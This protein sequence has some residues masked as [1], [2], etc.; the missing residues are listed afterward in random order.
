[1][2]TLRIFCRTIVGLVFIFSGFVKG[3][4]PLGSVYKF[5][6]YFE[7]YHT[8]WLSSLSLFLAVFLCAVEFTIGV[9]LV[10]GVKPKLSAWLAFIM[11]FFF[12]G[13]TLLS[14]INNPVSDC[15]CFGDAIKLTNWETFYKNIV[16][17]ILTLVLLLTNK[18]AKPAFS[19]K[20]EITIIILGIG[21][22]VFSSIYSLRHLPIIDFLPWK[23][24]N[25]I[26]EQVIPTPE[27]SEVFLVYKDK[28]TGEKFE[29]TAKTLPW[30][31]SVKMASIEFVE[32][33]K[34][35]TQPFK[36]APIHD[37]IIADADG[38][39][40][41]DQIVANPG[42]QF[43]LVAYDLNAT[44]KGAY[45]DI[46]KFVEGCDKDSISFVG[47]TGSIA[48]T[49][50]AFRQEQQTL[51]PFHNVDETA[52]KTM[53]RSNPGLLLLKDGVVLAKWG[54]RDIPEYSKVKE[55]YLK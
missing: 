42:Y 7:A 54:W 50:E 4:D 52:L 26:S 23:V 55:K 9:M 15:G 22:I 1:M 3:V 24:G 49:V 36:E 20:N 32:Q 31:D 43:I 10:F 40:V 30:Q 8:E 18:F 28:K 19:L 25:K 34:K 39:I 17:I 47:L 37:F 6:E 35:I 44:T 5:Q 14:A 46:N 2:R 48:E 51:Y 27:K 16:L 13:L 29:Y 12:T 45:A 38:N 11:M 41:T 53:I 33:K 21:V